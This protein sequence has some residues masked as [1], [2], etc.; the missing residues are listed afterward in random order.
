MQRAADFSL[1]PES[2]GRKPRGAGGRSARHRSLL[3][4]R[5][6]MVD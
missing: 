3:E 6:I 2:T 1:H 5:D 4:A